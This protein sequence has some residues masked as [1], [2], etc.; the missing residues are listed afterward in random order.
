MNFNKLWLLCKPLDV[1]LGT[2]PENACIGGFYQCA[3][4]HAC[5]KKSTRCLKFLQV[6]PHAAGLNGS[7]HC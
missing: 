4:F 3:K 7:H 5:F 6:M 2:T 1:H